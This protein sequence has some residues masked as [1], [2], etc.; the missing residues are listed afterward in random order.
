MTEPDD[1]TDDGA[2]L[3]EGPDSQRPLAPGPK[4]LKPR[5]TRQG[6]PRTTGGRYTCARC[7]G[8]TNRLQASWPEGQICFSCWFAAIRTRGTCA[9]CRRERLLPG[10]SIPGTQSTAGDS[11]S[12]GGPTC[13]TC[14]GIPGEFFCERC[15]LELGH[16]RGRICA[17]CALRDDLTALV[18]LDPSNSVGVDDLPDRLADDMGRV[19][20]ALCAADRPESVIVWKRS[21]KVQALLRGLGDGSIELSHAGLDTVPGRT[22]EHLR[23]V[24]QHHQVLPRRDV[25]LARFEQWIKAKVAGLPEEVQPPV[26]HF[27][28]WH[29]LRRIRAMEETVEQSGGS[30]RDSSALRGPVHSAKQEITETAKF[31]AWLHQ[32][33]GRTIETCVQD[34]VDQWIAEGPTT[35]SQIRTF[36]VTI[37][38]RGVNMNLKLG[39]RAART[40]PS[41]SQDQRLAWIAELL[42]GTSDSLP[43]RVAG[44]LLL[45][46]AQPLVRVVALR[47]DAIDDQP[48]RAFDPMQITLAPGGGSRPVGVPAPF[49]QLIRDHLANRPNL[50][51]GTGTTSPWLFPG[52]RAGSHLHAGSVMDRLRSLGINLLGARNRAFGELVLEAPPAIVADALGYSHGVAFDHA[53]KAAEPWARYAGRQISSA[54]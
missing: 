4:G 53:A 33:H 29:H 10:P 46:Y 2:D 20:D 49:D 11:G 36:L 54:P 37:H 23:A 47:V 28:T 24:L 13:T 39:H 26:E 16:Y 30:S 8:T 48:T 35:R 25:F 9:S 12:P 17:T 50:R 34:D 14:A 1:Q 15:G 21:P 7:H 3:P 6:R 40:S 51:T 38:A 5:S 52:G 41:L 31:L 18:G 43:Y 44:M 45:L 32:T 19:V 42:T 27:A 22:T